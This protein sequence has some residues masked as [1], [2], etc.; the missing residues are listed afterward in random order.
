M[1]HWRIPQAT[2]NHEQHPFGR[3]GPFL[4]GLP[5]KAFFGIEPGRGCFGSREMGTGRYSCVGLGN[6]GLL[7]SQLSITEPTATLV[8]T[9]GPFLVAVATAHVAR[10]PT[11]SIYSSQ[12]RVVPIPDTP[13]TPGSH[14][15]R[16]PTRF[17]KAE[18]RGFSPYL[19]KN[20]LVSYRVNPRFSR[21]A[22]AFPTP[23]ANLHKHTPRPRRCSPTALLAS[24][25][26]FHS[27]CTIDNSSFLR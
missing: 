16:Y 24:A 14:L 25:K 21:S 15:I 27:R 12:T 2:I 6:V 26:S 4:C 1:P 10:L 18:P 19:P 9:I 7:S 22:E 8:E 23:Y 13:L 3:P 5:G 20:C 11:G 17:G